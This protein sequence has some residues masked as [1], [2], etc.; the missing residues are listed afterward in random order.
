MNQTTTTEPSVRQQQ[1]EA[2][3]ARVAAQ[4]P[5]I[6]RVRVL[7]ASDDIRKYIKHP[8]GIKFPAT[9]S[10]EWPLDSFTRRRLRDGSVTREEQQ[11]EAEQQPHART[12]A[13]RDE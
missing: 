1:I 7:P 11:K 8:T 4:L 5:K 9:G 2:R 3:R 6:P 13:R 10:A 12:R